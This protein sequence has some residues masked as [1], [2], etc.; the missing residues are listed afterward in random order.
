MIDLVIDRKDRVVT[1]CE[2][3]YSELNSAITKENDRRLKEKISDFKNMTKTKS[4][5][6]L[7]MITTYGLERNKYAGHV[8]S[9]VISE[10]LFQQA[11]I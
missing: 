2:M 6:H 4:S 7:T 8:Q 9:V 10:D 1:L 11:R 5:I 3:K